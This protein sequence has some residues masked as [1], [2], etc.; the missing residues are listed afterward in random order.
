MMMSKIDRQIEMIEKDLGADADK[1]SRDDNKQIYF[2]RLKTLMYKLN[3]G[4][5]SYGDIAKKYDAGILRCWNF[6]LN[7]KVNK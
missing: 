4:E 6:M 1:V 2:I 3:G 5:I 7:K